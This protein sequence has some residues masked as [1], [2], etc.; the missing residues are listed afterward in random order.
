MQIFEQ[1]EHPYT[2]ALLAAVPGHREDFF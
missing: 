1:A 2:R